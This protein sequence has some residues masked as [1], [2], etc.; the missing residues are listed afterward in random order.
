MSELVP[1]L[2]SIIGKDQMVVVPLSMFAVE[3][4]LLD[5]NDKSD[6][7]N[8]IE[9]VTVKQEGHDDASKATKYVENI[10]SQVLL[11]CVLIIGAMVV[12]QGMK[13]V[14]IFST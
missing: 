6:L 3:A 9:S 7:I 1:K 10:N 8:I 2:A 12:R 14:Q 11:S 4:S 5:C 13:K